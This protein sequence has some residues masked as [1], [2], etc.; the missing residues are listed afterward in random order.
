M[1]EGR[2]VLS[3]YQKKWKA[4]KKMMVTGRVFVLPSLLADVSMIS[5]LELLVM[6]WEAETHQCGD[7]QKWPPTTGW[8]KC[9]GLD[10]FHNKEHT[11]LNTV[12]A[13]LHTH[14]HTHTRIFKNPQKAEHGPKLEYIIMSVLSEEGC[15]PPGTL[16]IYR[17]G[18]KKIIKCWFFDA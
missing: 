14:T 12:S 18:E 10:N 7:R 16:L 5:S 6:R 9:I 3:L 15:G 13:E 4:L 17:V 1:V 11:A 2:H 8:V